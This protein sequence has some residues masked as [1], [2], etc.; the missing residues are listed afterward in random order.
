VGYD[1]L[2][3]K[4]KIGF[5]LDKEMTRVT[6]GMPVFN[7]KIFLEESLRSILGQTFSDF[8]LVISDDCSSDGSAEICRQYAAMDPRITYIRQPKNLGISRNMEFLLAQATTTYF[9]WA[10]DDDVYDPRF[11][12]KHVEG[13]DKNPNA[14]SAFGSVALIDEQGSTL[15]GNLAMDYSEPNRFKRLKNF[16]KNSTDY[17]G[18][19]MFRR[20]AIQGVKFPVW[21]WPNKKSAYNNIYP[22]LCFY[23]AKGDYVH[24]DGLPLF[25]KRVKTG[26]N[27]PHHLTGQ[28]NAIKETFA[29][30]IRKFNLVLFATKMIRKGSGFNLAMKLLPV[31]LYFWFVM[32]SFNQLCLASKS[33]WKN[34]VLGRRQIFK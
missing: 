9:M 32:P 16:I 19:G 1:F 7:D 11:I 28:G 14:V 29:F 27:N 4:V 26:S 15:T 6:I 18:Y 24:I 10:G 2:F 21:W 22:S 5:R 20:E 12:E 31:M 3:Q 8:Q 33:F 30:W 13:L 23:L 25:F 17:F 34:R